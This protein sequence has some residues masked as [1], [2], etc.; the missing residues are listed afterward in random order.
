MIWSFAGPVILVALIN[1]VFLVSAL[2]VVATHRKHSTRSASKLS[3]WSG[4]IKSSVV[5]LRQVLLM[6]WSYLFSSLL[7]IT[8]GLGVF[9]VN[10][11]TTFVAYLFTIT[12]SLQGKNMIAT[13]MNPHKYHMLAQKHSS[14]AGFYIF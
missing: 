3:T 1:F 5:L 9:F 2:R 6:E 14:V 11:E 8:W 13:A 10:V 7:G 12:N 4:W